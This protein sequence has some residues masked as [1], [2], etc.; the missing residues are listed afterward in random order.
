MA[1]P[2]D[3][4]K[5]LTLPA[6]Q[7]GGDVSPAALL[8]ALVALADEI[9]ALRSNPFP[10]HRRSTREAIRQVGA[11]LEFLADVRGRGSALPASAAVGFSELHV[12][13]QKLRHLLR[14]CARPG[15]RLWVLMRSELVSNEF[16]VLVRSIST[17][18]DVLPLASIDAAPE[19]KE[20]VRLVREQAWRA[21]VGTVPADAMAV[22]SMWSILG[23]FK[24]G[25]APNRIDLRWI[26]DHLRIRSWNDCSEEIAFL[27]EL[28]F[29]SLDDGEEEEAEAALLGNLMAFMVYCRAVLFDAVDDEKS[30]EKQSQARARAVSHV[31]VDHL[32]CPISLEFM[33]DP[34]TIATGQTYD[35]ASISKWLKSGCL[36]CPVTGEKLAN[37]SLVPNSAVRNLMEQLC[38]ETKVPIPEPNGKPKRDL[39]RTATPLS[40]AAAG[41]T[42]M[43]SAFL[44]HRLAVG[45]NQEKNKAAHE[46][47]KLA[48]SNI[49]NRACLVEAGSVPWLLYHLSSSDPS[50]QD[51]AVAALMSLSKHPSGGKAIVEAGGLG[52]VVDVIR[53]ALRVEAQQNAA[54]ILFYL[55]SDEE[56]RREIGR[57]A[58][59]TPTLVEL[60][61]EGTY[62]G[63]KNAIVT[64]YGL[65]LCPDNLRKI[66]AAGAIPALTTILSSDR[67]DLVNDAVA[68]LAKIA[69]GH[70]GTTAILKS[71]AVPH[72]VGFL[73]S[74][75]S[76]SG[77]ENC[78]SALLSLCNNGGAKVVS[79]LEQMPVL[80]PS[81]YSLVTE[82]S[83]Q[84]GKKARSLLNHIHHLHDQEDLVMMGAV[85]A[86]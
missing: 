63:R 26:L 57:M 45:T 28:F 77:R 36:T 82:G 32:R 18:L 78:V 74:S 70:D 81:L 39:T 1:H 56:Y 84:A 11:I 43:V 6:V 66:L 7:P 38:H 60:L 31:N 44:V 14:D 42:R 72:L 46:I 55:S 71:S 73:R 83:P 40:A 23:Q 41:A 67:A 49:F 12:A 25:I 68:V 47:R 3:R 65:L 15:A 30:S 80:M 17:A 21:T 59:A 10:I 75:T 69:E 33:M 24:N 79:L 5:F 9:L 53:V 54:A 61:R 52:L 50:I 62:R 76:R 16:Q 34:V 58:E 20:L 2:S 4:R 86:L 22:R 85:D 13:L 27:E 51:N 35:R 48:K 29:A 19:I 37:T 64:L 8:C